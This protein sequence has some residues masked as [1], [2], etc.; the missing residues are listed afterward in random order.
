MQI[1]NAAATEQL[2]ALK[3]GKISAVDL[4]EATLALADEITPELN[5][6][7]L[8][9]YSRA[10][11]AAI[12]A[13]KKL[14]N[15]EGGRLCGLPI[16][17]KD[18]QFLAGY[19]CANGSHTLSEFVPVETCRAVE[20]LEQEGAII[21][22]K[23]TCPEFSLTGITNSNLYGLTSNPWDI[24]RTSGGSSGGA[25]V[26][27][28]SGLGAFSLGGDGGGSIRIPAGFCGIVGFKPSFGAIPREP[29]FPSWQS[30]VSYGPMTRSVKDAQLFYQILTGADEQKKPVKLPGR[31]IVSEDLGFAPVDP[32]VRKAFRAVIEKI[33]NSGIKTIE[34]Q[35]GLH[36][37]V[38]TWAVTAS[39]DAAEKARG[40]PFEAQDMGVVAQAF[41][42]FGDTFSEED[43]DEAQVYRQVI[44]DH[45]KEM[46]KRNRSNI[47][48]TP[49]L[50]CEAFSHGSIH[51]HSIDGNP[52][53]APWLD[54]AGFLYDANLAEMPAC[55]IPMGLGDQGLPLSIQIIGAVGNDDEV[56]CVA[57][58]IEKLIG[59]DNSI[60]AP[61]QEPQPNPVLA[62]KV[63]SEMD[64]HILPA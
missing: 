24:G 14:A 9:L 50:G 55:A 36:S 19:R 17:I 60:V 47:L 22:A 51:P 61:K 6:F 35:P 43:F 41:I 20:I 28:A 21:F 25:A 45:Y 4:L 53:E 10:R 7:A 18:S 37:S 63:S 15:G 62:K 31:V 3:T 64:H 40:K 2:Q 33:H 54:W 29:C 44:R 59:W 39:Y 34:D 57:A 11:Q 32:D 5:P 8:T 38:V 49:T 27:V 1:L 58:A 12:E 48:I 30:I 46:F 13:D 56:L 23:T 26:A 52:I 16:T 42:E